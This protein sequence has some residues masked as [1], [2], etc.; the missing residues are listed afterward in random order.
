V[1]AADIE[2]RCCELAARNAALNRLRVRRLRTSLQDDDEQPAANA[3]GRCRPDATAGDASVAEAGGGMGVSN[4]GGGGE[5]GGSCTDGEGG[6]R[7]AR[8][9]RAASCAWCAATRAHCCC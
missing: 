9:A 1:T 8:A 6:E 3:H 2:P 4:Q 5:G 7:A